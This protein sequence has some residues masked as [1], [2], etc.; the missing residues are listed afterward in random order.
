MES[1]ITPLK[2]YTILA[3][4]LRERRMHPNWNPKQDSPLLSLMDDE[5]KLL[6]ES[7]REEVEKYESL[8][9]RIVHIIHDEIV[10]MDSGMDAAEDGPVST[11]P[12]VK[13][14]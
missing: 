14:P 8:W 1:D 13:L 2:R 5:Y 10:W 11:P 9:P 6:S 3:R 4:L 7:E 12:R